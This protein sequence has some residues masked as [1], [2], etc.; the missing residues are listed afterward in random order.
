MI[1][2]GQVFVVVDPGGRDFQLEWISDT[3]RL[4]SLQS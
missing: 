3:R 4:V 1:Y 2:L